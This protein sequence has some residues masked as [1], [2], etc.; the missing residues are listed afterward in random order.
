MGLCKKVWEVQP[1]RRHLRIF[2][3][4]HSRATTGRYVE[5]GVNIDGYGGVLRTEFKYGQLSARK[6]LSGY[7]FELKYIFGVKVSVILESGVKK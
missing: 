7:N 3:T 6:L 1:C 2:V 4:R 5:K